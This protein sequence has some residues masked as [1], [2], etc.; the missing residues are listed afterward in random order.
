[1]ITFTA[2]SPIITKPISP[3]F[4]AVQTA[5]VPIDAVPDPTNLPAKLYTLMGVPSMAPAIVISVC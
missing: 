5:V 4:N 1:M 2:F 3:L